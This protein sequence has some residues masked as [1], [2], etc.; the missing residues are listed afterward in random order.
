MGDVVGTG[1]SK[2]GKDSC[3]QKFCE[4]IPHLVAE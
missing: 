4:H 1:S 3:R 2:C